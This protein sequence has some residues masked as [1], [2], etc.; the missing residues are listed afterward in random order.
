MELTL[1]LALARRGLVGL[2]VV[3]TVADGQLPQVRGGLA[4][5]AVHGAL[6][7]AAAPVL[8]ARL[9]GQVVGVALG[10]CGEVI[11]TRGEGQGRGQ[12]AP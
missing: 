2:V 11:R 7:S 8:L 4:G 1:L 9:V 6:A 5:D 10:A 3:F 12:D